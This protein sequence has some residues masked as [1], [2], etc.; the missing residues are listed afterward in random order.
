V[1]KPAAPFASSYAQA[2][3]LFLE[4]AARAGLAAEPLVHPLRGREGEE[5]ALDV[6]RDGP[7]DADRLLILSSA[8]HGVEGYCGS[9][10]QVAALGDAQWRARAAGAGVAVLYLHGLNPWGFS[11]MLRTT[12]ENVDLNRNFHDFSQPLPHN[13]AYAQLHALLVPGAWPPSA[14]HEQALDA[15]IAQHGQ[16]AFQAAVSGGQ[17]QFAGGMFFG[18]T[19]PCWSNGALRQVLRAHAT[20]ATRLAWIDVHTGL[21]PSGVGER[22]FAGPDDAA[23]VA[24][25]RAWWSGGGRTPVTSIWDGSSSSARLTG[26]MC[27]AVGQECPQAQYTGI[28]MEYGT[29][30]VMQTLQAVRAGTWLHAHLEDAPPALADAIRR[31]VLAAFYTET[32]AWKLAIL[33]QA[34]ESMLQAVAGLSGH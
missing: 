25:A 3:T 7:A 6:V 12:H 33:Q 34:R 4:A 30:P 8:C 9:G 14:A 23:A 29:V 21:G 27:M 19:A 1:T 17:Y 26:L 28:A 15:W 24:R 2:R 31:Q 13:A 5:L 16:A 32:E 10:V 20:R 11:H 22:I 18:G